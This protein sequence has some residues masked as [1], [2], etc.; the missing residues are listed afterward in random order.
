MKDGNSKPYENTVRY[1]GSRGKNDNILDKMTLFYNEPGSSGHLP[2]PPVFEPERNLSERT[3][4]ILQSYG[5]F[6]AM[7]SNSMRLDP[8]GPTDDA[9]NWGSLEDI[10]NAVHVLTGGTGKDKGGGHMSYVPNSAFDPIFWLR[11]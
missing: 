2:K 8:G 6:A 3:A 4:Y 11:E 1:P 7:S 10:H 5:T 9:P